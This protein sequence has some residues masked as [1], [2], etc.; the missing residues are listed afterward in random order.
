MTIRLSESPTSQPDFYQA[1]CQALSGAQPDDAAW[2]PSDWEHFT[3]LAQA[4]SVA[5][6]LYAIWRQAG[7]PVGLL[8]EQQAIFSQAYFQSAGR[9]AVYRTELAKIGGLFAQ[10]GIDCLPLKGAALAGTLYP[11]PATRPMSDLDLLVR[12]QHLRRALAILRRAGY[13]LENFTYHAVLWGPVFVE[14]H[15]SLPYP[16]GARRQPPEPWFWE[17]QAGSAT[18][19]PC[20]ALLLHAIVHQQVQN[21]GQ[22]RLLSYLDLLYLAQALGPAYHWPALQSLASDFGWEPAYTAALRGVEQRFPGQ[23]PATALAALPA[24]TSAP[25]LQPALNPRDRYTASAWRHLDL[26]TRLQA[27]L[28]LVFPGRGYMLW[29]YRPRPAWLWPLWYPLRWGNLARGLRA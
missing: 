6:R 2:T 27:A 1:L 7:F 19:P 21:H 26:L 25:A 4:E 17:K 24:A 20:D 23:V 16:Q 18:E 8:P 29:R 22:G 14:L 11:D 12:P 15:W 10:A 28:S 9:N 5:P 3:R 13:S